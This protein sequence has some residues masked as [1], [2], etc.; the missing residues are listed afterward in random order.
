MPEGAAPCAVPRHPG[1]V[2]HRVVEIDLPDRDIESLNLTP[3]EARLDLAV[4]LYARR[5]V[6]LG[7]AARIAGVSYSDVLREIGQRG[8]CVDYTFED[9][10]ADVD[11][12]LRMRQP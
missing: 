4:G 5:R 9:A 7:R 8:L 6:S 2:Y 3:E 1:R 10:Q 11:L 12:V